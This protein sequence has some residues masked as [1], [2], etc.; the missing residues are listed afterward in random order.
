MVAIASLNNDKTTAVVEGHGNDTTE[1]EQIIP[2]NATDTD[3][4]EPSADQGELKSDNGKLQT[5]ASKKSIRF[6]AIIAALAFSNLL[7]ALEATVTSTALPTITAELGGG[8]LFIWVVNGYFL[9]QYVQ[10]LTPTTR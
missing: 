10:Q 6:Y 4:K 3:L 8:E 9:T 1:L 5:V 7:T 2:N